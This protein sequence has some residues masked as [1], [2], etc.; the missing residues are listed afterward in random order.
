L[1]KLALLITPEDKSNKQQNQVGHSFHFVKKS[2]FI[3]LKNPVRSLSGRPV[4]IFHPIRFISEKP[5]DS[6]F[7]C[8]DKRSLDIHIW[9]GWVFWK[10][11]PIR[12]RF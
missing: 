6:A 2:G 12:I 8:S 5:S 1:E 7:F 4:Q 10:S 11:S 9:S 3:S